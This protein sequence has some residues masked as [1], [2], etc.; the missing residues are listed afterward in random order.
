MTDH[1]SAPGTTGR[2]PAQ[3]VFTRILVAGALL[4]LAIAVVGGV[5]GF[6]V[7]GGRGV[8]SAVIGSAMALVFLGITAGSIL[9]AQRFRASDSY[10]QLF[11]GIVLGAWIVKFGVF[12]A[13]TLALKEQPWINLVVLFVTI[14]VGVIG[15]LVMDVVVISRA[16]MP[17]VSDAQLPR[18]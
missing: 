13:I 14:V 5:V 10:P 7:D 1:T 9:F 2:T 11:F 18:S 12:L 16:R 8:V 4:A 17:Y 6:A 15:A 3:A